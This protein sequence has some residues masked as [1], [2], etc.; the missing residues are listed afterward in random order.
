MGISPHLG[1]SGSPSTATALGVKV[2]M[3]SA[4]NAV[5]STSL[6]GKTVAIQV[7]VLFP[8]GLLFHTHVIPRLIPQGLGG[9]GSALVGYLLESGVSKIIGSDV[10]EH[11]ITDL[12]RRHEEERHRL[13]LR[14]ELPHTP[15]DSSIVSEECDVFSPCAFGGVLNEDSVPHIKASIVCGSANNQLLDPNSDCGM[16]KRGVTF[17]PDVVC[18]RMGIVNVSCE[19]FGSYSGGMVPYNTDDPLFTRHLS[20]EWEHSIYQV[21]AKIIRMARDQQMTTSQ[22]AQLLADEYVEEEHPICG[23]RSRDIVQ[24]LVE[25]GWAC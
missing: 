11:R 3:E 19:M 16:Q 7:N 8:V 13:C 14:L 15:Y 20:R 2:A 12:L 24:S 10:S 4:L 9:V 21:A 1:G 5:A 22:A 18:S 23:H 25:N 6:E 17:V